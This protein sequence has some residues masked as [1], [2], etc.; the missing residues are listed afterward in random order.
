[1]V[2][3][4]IFVLMLVRQVEA[5]IKNK[6][7]AGKV[8]LLL[9]A[10]Q[11][12]KS[13]LLNQL[14]AQENA[15]WLDA[16]NS[17]VP[18][19]FEMAT[20]T[21]LKNII[22]N[23]KLLIIDEAQR[24]ANIGSALKLCTDYFKDVQVIATGSSAFELRNKTNEPLTGRKWEYYLY[25]FSFA[26][27]VNHTSLL[28]EKRNINQRLLYGSY[29]EIVTH[30]ADAKERLKL[31]CDSYL[32]R[33]ILLWA[34]LKKPDK[35]MDLLKALALQIGSE[36]SFNELGNKIG[37]KADTV[38]QYIQL[39]EQ[40]FI[41]F[42]LPAYSRNVRK[43][44]RRS[45]KYYFYDI[46]IRN[47]L[48]NQYGPLANRP[49]TGAIWENYIIAEL[50]KKYNIENPFVNFYFWRTQDQQEIDLIVDDGENLHAYE[51]KYSSMAKARLSK[52]FANAYPNHSFTVIH[53]ENYTDYLSTVAF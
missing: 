3:T 40:A 49:D 44:L 8:I 15:L 35:I 51:I 10:R 32:Y 38:E 17:D 36:V 14:F 37:L 24:I 43:E 2:K 28:E 52:T 9:G 39:F 16:E 47:A 33:D 50:K 31:L 26:E 30:P 23:H 48:L 20:V 25:P 7:F 1:M 22:G 12:G 4:G 27:L 18:P 21:S 46:G 29:P 5:I 13:T 42:K 34:G 19:L 6:L 11:V 41:V 53:T 45:R